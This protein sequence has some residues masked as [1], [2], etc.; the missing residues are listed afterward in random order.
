MQECTRRA[1][2]NFLLSDSVCLKDRGVFK[3]RLSETEISR[4]MQSHFIQWEKSEY[5]VNLSVFI[6][7]CRNFILQKCYYWKSIA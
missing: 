6:Y 1:K 7:F 2:I 3:Y 5:L 4:E